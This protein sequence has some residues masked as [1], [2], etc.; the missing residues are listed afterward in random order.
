MRRDDKNSTAAI[1]RVQQYGIDPFVR[2]DF[3]MAATGL[4]KSTLYKYIAEGTFPKP[5]AI[6]GRAVGWQ[7]SV[8]RE[9]M[10]KRR[11]EDKT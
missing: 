1:E 9:W 5:K 8:I 3:V 10:D 4:A 11:A 7:L 2:V 6:S